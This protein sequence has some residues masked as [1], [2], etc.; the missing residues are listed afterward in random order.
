M[1]P[2]TSSISA[3]IRI[4][5]DLF[6]GFAL[7]AVSWLIW[8]DHPKWWGFGLLSLF[9]VCGGV[10]FLI[11]AFRAMAR[12]RARRGVLAAQMDNAKA[13]KAATLAG[14]EKLK[15]AGML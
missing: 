8:P 11:E 1:T 13:Q 12:L 15:D 5:F 2:K 7:L 10:C 14:K 4:N 9:L 6:M 3:I